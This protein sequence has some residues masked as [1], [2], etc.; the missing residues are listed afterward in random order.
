MDIKLEK[1]KGIKAILRMKNMPYLL[2]GIVV[3]AI[4]W[5]VFRDH[6]ST[7]RIDARTIS[8]GKVLKGEF[9]DYISVS[10]QVLPFTTVQLSPLEAGLVERILVEEGADVKKGDILVELSN[11]NL[12]L[13][14]LNSEA[15]LAEKQNFLRNTMVT[16]EQE[17]LNLRKEQLQLDSDLTRKR[18]TYNQNNE[19]YKDGL[20]SK[21]DWLRSKEDYELADRS[22]TLVLERQKQDSLY[23]SVQIGQLEE[24]LETMQKNMTL[25]RE[26]VSNLKVRSIID[27]ELGLFDIVLGQ[28]VGSGQKIGQINDLSNYKIEAN[29]DEH[30]IDRVRSGLSASFDRQG[31]IFQTNLR[32][33]YPEVREGSFRA[34]FSFKGERPEN[35]RS[36]QTYHLNL[37]LGQPTDAILIPRGSFYQ[38]TGGKWVYV[39]DA[40]GETAYR[41]NIRIGRYNPQ[42]Y[43]VLEGLDVGEEVILSS[44]DSYGD[45]DVLVLNK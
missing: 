36:G 4:L 25:I 5:L 15:Q 40:S 26:R 29:I 39:I 37:E 32:K 20:I 42:Y 17:R 21:E 41:R 45:N 33:V 43:E 19:L 27:G 44:Y 16:M 28:S 34:D 3:V 38:S 22:R 1:K 18:R 8:M 23:R 7:M 35:I 24:N 31:S 2:G 14:I 6:S 13:E 11:N 9:N 12:N 10:G 30:Y